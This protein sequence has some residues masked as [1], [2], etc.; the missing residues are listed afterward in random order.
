[1][2]RKVNAGVK[3]GGFKRFGHRSTVKKE[4]GNRILKHQQSREKQ[5]DRLNREMRRRSK[6]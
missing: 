2:N 1:M 3:I 6:L 5:V 4:H